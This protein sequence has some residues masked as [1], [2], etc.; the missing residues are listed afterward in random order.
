MKC[1]FSILIL[2]FIISGCNRRES[3]IG[4]TKELEITAN[5]EK[6]IIYQMGILNTGEQKVLELKLKNTLQKP[7]IINDVV[8][9][10]GCTSAEF[11]SKLIPYQQSSVIKFTFVADHVGIFSKCIKIYLDSQQ[12][13]VQILFKGEIVSKNKNL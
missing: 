2:I 13:P 8:R 10:C 6:D 9:F 4:E 5:V 12:K 1:F 3:N 11:E 7:V